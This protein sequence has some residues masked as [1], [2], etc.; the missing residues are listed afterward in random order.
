MKR[1]RTLSLKRETLAELTP[2]EMA[3]VN[4]G[5]HVGCGTTG[6]VTHVSFDACPT[7]PLNDCFVVDTGS[8]SRK[9]CP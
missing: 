9:F 1:T 8:I 2:A 4:G 3:A 6:A 7:V 5:T